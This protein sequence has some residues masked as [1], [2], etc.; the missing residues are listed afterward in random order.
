M[1]HLQEPSHLAIGK[2]P[3]DVETSLY[4]YVVVRSDIPPGLQGAQAIHAALE[5]G[6]RFGNPEGLRVSFLQAANISALL[7]LRC[8]LERDG[9]DYAHFSEPDWGIG[10]SALASCPIHKK[11][12]KAFKRARVWNPSA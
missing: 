5:A 3:H 4:C 9:I 6:R 11:Q 10:L 1:D 7:D 8:A 2:L 12:A